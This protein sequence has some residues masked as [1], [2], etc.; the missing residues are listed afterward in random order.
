MEQGADPRGIAGSKHRLEGG[1]PVFFTTPGP[2]CGLKFKEGLI[3]IA[4]L[5]ASRDIVPGGRRL[6]DY[7]QAI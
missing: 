3:E 7:G 1:E 5:S 2:L 6:P 4:H